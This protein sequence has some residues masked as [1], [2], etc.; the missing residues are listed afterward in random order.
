MNCKKLNSVFVAVVIAQEN[1]L[2]LELGQ[3][4]IKKKIQ[5]CLGFSACELEKIDRSDKHLG[6]GGIA[7]SGVFIHFTYCLELT[8]VSSVF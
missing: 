6:N 1:I 2:F 5:I 4:K 3:Y 7:S 8:T